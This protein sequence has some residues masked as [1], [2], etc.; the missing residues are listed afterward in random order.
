[1][2][3]NRACLGKS[4]SSM[5]A[6]V[7]LDS[8]QNYARACNDHNPRYFD[9]GVP[10]GIVAPPLYAVVVTWLPLISAMTDPELGAN[11]L[12]LLHTAQDME[13]FAP[14]RPGDR[15]SAEARIAA[16]QVVG[17]GESLI[18]E[19]HASNQ[20]REVISR[21]R[22]TVLIR[23]RRDPASEAE[24]R[25]ADTGN[26]TRGAPLCL[27]TETIARDQT[28]RYAAASG[29][30]NPIHVDENVAKM[31]AL[32]GI[33]VHGLCAMAFAAR[34][35]I[36]QLCGSDPLRLN[37]LAVRFVRPIFP[38]DSLTTS[39]WPADEDGE[40]HRFAFTTAN[41]SGAIVMRDGR[42]EISP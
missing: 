11:L 23:G 17:G 5:P 41:A 30:R 9:S 8:L 27:V 7:T 12:R 6:E 1:M 13:F 15:I 3:L 31:A 38:G 22:F 21:I 39:I 29:D 28:W 24:S 26:S 4:Y 19:L 16:V 14:I 35:V 25:A 36:D 32:P 2:P 33:I 37:Q 18:L 34:A 20:H 40:H 10:G 42:A